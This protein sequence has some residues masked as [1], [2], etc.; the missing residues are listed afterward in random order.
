MFNIP[1]QNLISH[2]RFDLII[3]LLYD[4]VPFE[5]FIKTI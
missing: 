3:K 5:D 4:Y 1:A 2:T